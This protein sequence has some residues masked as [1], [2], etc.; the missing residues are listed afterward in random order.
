MFHVIASTGRTAT[1]FI[2]AVLNE[3]EGVVACHEGY[4]GSD[5]ESEPLL[6]LINLENNLAYQ[7]PA[8]AS[9]IVEEKRSA[10]IIEAALA[11]S[12][13]TTLVDVAY[14]N[15]SIAL[16]LLK[17]HP[18]LHLVGLIR[19]AEEFVRSATQLN[20]EDLL[21]V[22]WPDPEKLL[23]DRE[24]FIGFGRIRPRRGTPEKAAWDNWSAIRRNVWL[25]QETNLLLM[26]VRNRFP[27]RVSLIDFAAL[28]QDPDQFWEKLCGTLSLSDRPDVRDSLLS[29]FR[30][31][32][33]GGPQ[34]GPASSWPEEERIALERA[35]RT[36]RE[37]WNDAG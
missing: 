36:I 3:I 32:K 22:G 24:K 5:H 23:S 8:N 14:Y 30:N 10:A 34:I 17:A 18:Q 37:K 29:M 7:N 26:E 19:D 6:P 1:T 20:G 15:P 9:A 12:G 13:V 11:K 27:D 25:W 33:S 28:R 2:A 31:R 4:V 21:P 35:S 16:A